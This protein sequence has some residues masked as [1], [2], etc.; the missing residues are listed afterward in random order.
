MNEKIMPWIML[1]GTLFGLWWGVTHPTP[2]PCKGL[3]GEAHKDCVQIEEDKAAFNA[4]TDPPYDP[5]HN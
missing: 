2:D 5:T 1:A 3:R 4:E